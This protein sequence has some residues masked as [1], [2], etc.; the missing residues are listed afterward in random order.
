LSPEGRAAREAHITLPNELLAAY[1]PHTGDD[2]R[3]LA[4]IADPKA[5]DAHSRLGSKV[6]LNKA[7]D[8]TVLALGAVYPW[9]SL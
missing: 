1:P 8:G 3:S 7:L 5:V 4:D 9:K 2:A 6:V